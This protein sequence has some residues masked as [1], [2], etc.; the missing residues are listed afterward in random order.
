MIKQNRKNGQVHVSF[1]EYM[2]CM[3]TQKN[4]FVTHSMGNIVN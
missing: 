1:Q 4:E 3:G 2:T